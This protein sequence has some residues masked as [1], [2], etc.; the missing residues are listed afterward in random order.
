MRDVATTESAT[1]STTDTLKR[2]AGQLQPQRRLVR[3]GD[4]VYQAGERFDNLYILNSGFYKIVNLTADGREQVV[5]LKFRGDWLGFEGIAGGCYGCDAVAMDTGEVWVVPYDALM[6]ACC[7]HP[8][9]MQVLHAAMSR[10]IA[11]DRDSLMSVCTLPADARVADFLRYWAE[12][13]AERGMRTDQITLRMTRAEI[14][15]YLGMTLESVSRA[16][17]RLARDKVIGFAEKGRRDVQIPD[18]GALSAFVQRCLAPVPVA[19]PAPAM[20]Q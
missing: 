20:L 1:E 10:E 15:N 8:G 17:S 12:S 2:L 14:G 7:V 16:L 5:G 3:T 18:V 9:L 19:V 11:N 13:L 4:V 6:A